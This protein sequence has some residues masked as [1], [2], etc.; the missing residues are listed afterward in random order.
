MTLVARE[1]RGPFFDELEVGAE[2][3]EAPAV[4]LT[5]GLAATHHA[6]VGNR[7]RLAIDDELCQSVTGQ[8]GYVSPAL[9]WDISIGQSTAVTQQ[10]RANLFYRGLRFQRYP[11]IG[12]T[13][14][15][16]TTVDALRRN[17]DRPGR[18]R[19]GMAALH[20][21]TTD[22]LGRIVL[23][24]WRCAMLP[25]SPGCDADAPRDELDAIGR[26]ESVRPQ[27]CIADWDL[28]L[29]RAGV[30]GE[31]F[32]DIDVGQRWIVGG[33]DVVSSA[34]ELARLAG[35]IAAVHHDAASAGGSRLVYGGHTIG[36]A[37]H[38]VSR[39]MPA[40]V[41]VLGWESCDHLAPVHEGDA[42]ESVIEVTSAEPVPTGGGLVSLHVV[43]SAAPLDEP[44]RP[45]LDW[46]L[47]VVLA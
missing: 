42:L 2:F 18:P 29:F 21:V 13:L 28:A 7:L 19:T 1:V 38:Q 44:Q 33:A 30:P 27:T 36:L 15:T 45:V 17:Q 47:T 9:V 46:R 11:R 35:N 12:D 14:S 26:R 41:T 31:H 5:S 23:D 39:A 22:Q 24:Y 10:V 16:V 3:T 37:L 4:T 8:R 43:T 32:A 6:I 25:V 20:I 34:P 40:V